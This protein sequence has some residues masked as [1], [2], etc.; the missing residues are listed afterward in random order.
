MK[1]IVFFALSLIF[2]SCKYGLNEFL[3]R[4]DDVN[5]RSQSLRDVSPPASSAIPPS[6]AIFTCLILTDVHFGAPE[7][8]PIDELIAWINSLQPQDKPLF[9]L[10][11]GDLVESGKESQYK[12]Y[13]AFTARLKDETG[14]SAFDTYAVA[15]NHDLYNSG[16]KYW[17]QYAAPH[18]SYYRFSAAGFSWYFLDSANGTL[19]A[20][21]LYDF[22]D[23]A[24]SD[25]R[26]KLIFSHYPVYA[27]G[28]F[29]FSMSNS[30]ER[31]LLLDTFARTNTKLVLTGHWHEGGSYDFGA[32]K[33]TTLKAF[34]QK[35]KWYTLAVDET[36]GTAE[37]RE[38]GP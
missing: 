13:A 23:R 25:S 28:V 22:I 19:G 9:C 4:N 15:G 30:R 10:V 29:Y 37:L 1:K 2:L 16:W 20:N 36:A 8:A 34:R 24:K 33:E 6:P 17:K 26:P 14:M 11:L 35:K 7:Y 38:H 3:S 18:L 21:Q 5:D 31:A 32:F 12:E 27:G